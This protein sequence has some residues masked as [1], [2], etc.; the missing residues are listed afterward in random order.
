MEAWAE[1]TS[2]GVGRLQRC[3]DDLVSVL[4]LP[5][6]WT[7]HDASRVAITLLEATVRI[8]ALDFAYACVDDSV[9]G[10]SMEWLRRSDGQGPGARAHDVGESLQRH[11][12]DG[13]ATVI[14]LVANPV[15]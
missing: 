4:A 14:R 13:V 10:T 12:V 3:I 15:S 6:I 2:G 7:G 5:A 8:L 11:L 9:E 1:S